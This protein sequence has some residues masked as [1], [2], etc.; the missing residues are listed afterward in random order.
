MSTNLRLETNNKTKTREIE[1]LL[2]HLM[3]IDFAVRVCRQLMNTTNGIREQNSNFH[4]RMR[5]D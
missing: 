3:A 4:N 5:I 1:A 2:F